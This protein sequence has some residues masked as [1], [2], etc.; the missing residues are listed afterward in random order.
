MHK[1][2]LK[3]VVKST[4]ILT[5]W[6]P[7]LVNKVLS[8]LTPSNVR[9]I[10]T[11]KKFESITTETEPYYGIKYKTEK[12]SQD[13]LKVW[14]NAVLDENLHLPDKN[15]FIPSEFELCGRE[16]NN[17]KVPVVLHKSP[18]T[19]VWFCQDNEFLVPKARKFGRFRGH[20]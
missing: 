3:D 1:Y 11:A 15:H 2:D 5:E 18:H 14:E 8:H 4:Y 6:K 10:V 16:I 9:M 19:R 12:N 7:D 17:N 20:G 13:V